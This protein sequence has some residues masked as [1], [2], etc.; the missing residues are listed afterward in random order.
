MILAFADVTRERHWIHTDEGRVRAETPYQRLVAH[1]FLTLS[2]LTS[3]AGECFEFRGARRILNQGLD[4]LR[5]TEV[6]TAGD[7]IRLRLKLNAVTATER[8]AR[9]SWQCV[10]EI[11]GKLRPALVTDFIW[12]VEQT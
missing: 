12:A 11:E 10:V 1:G 8:G 3:L 2:L 6:V 5:F 9:L 4:R 7:R